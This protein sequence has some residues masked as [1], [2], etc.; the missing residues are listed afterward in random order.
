MLF[1][2]KRLAS[3]NEFRAQLKDQAATF[4]PRTEHMIL[5][6]RLD[7][8]IRTLRESRALLEGKASQNSVNLATI[9]SVIGILFGLISLAMKLVGL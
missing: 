7:E 8:D 2:S 1:R 3:M 9:L 5:H 4:V 6:D